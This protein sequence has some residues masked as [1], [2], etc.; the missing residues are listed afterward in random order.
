MSKFEMYSYTDVLNKEQKTKYLLLGNGFSIG[1]DKVFDYGN[2]FEYAKE[3]G[4]TGHVHKVFEYLGTN[5]FEGVLRLLEQ[6]KWVID[7]YDFVQKKGSKSSI[8]EDLTSIKNALVVAITKTHLDNPNR[9]TDEKKKQCVNFLLPYKNIFTTNYD[10]LLYWIS[11][12]GQ[13]ELQERD[14]FRSLPEEPDAEYLVFHE[15]LGPNKGILFLHGAIHLYAE[16]GEVRKHSWIR[17]SQMRPLVDVVKEGLEHRQYPLFV[18]EGNPEKKLEQ[19]LRNHYL[20]YCLGK[21]ERIESSLIIYGL[22]L[23]ESDTHIC[24]TIADNLS[25]GNIYIGLYEPPSSNGSQ[26]IIATAHKMQARRL[27]S[28]AMGKKGKEL[29]VYYYDSKTVRVWD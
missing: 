5:N 7:H 22:S 20:S 12:Y 8:D 29:N 10:L 9:V 11:M 15:H 4:L 24:N 26:T 19:I 6:S 13:E 14:G 23:C 3:N 27:K 18:A 21:L 16:H 2:L 25:L 28:L 1:C 17:D